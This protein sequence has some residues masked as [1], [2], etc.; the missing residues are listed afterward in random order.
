M[1]ISA[2]SLEFSISIDRQSIS[3]ALSDVERAFSRQVVGIQVQTERSALEQA[4]R[5]IDNAFRDKKVRVG[6]DI[7]A[8]Q[9]LDLGRQGRQGARQF[10]DGFAADIAVGNIVADGVGAAIDLIG[11]GIGAVGNFAGSVAELG[12][13][14]EQ[15]AIAFETILGS[16]EAAESTLSDLQNFAANTPFEFTGVRD[17]GQSLLAFGFQ[18]QELIPALTAVGNVA[19]G[20]GADFNELALIYGKARTQGTLFAEDINQLTERGIPIIAQLAEQFGV[21]ESQIKKLVSEG[22]VTFADLETAFTSLTSE[23]GTFFNLIEKQSATFGGR[24]SNLADTAD[25]FKIALFDAF[26]P[27]LTAAIGT[28]GDIFAEVARQSDGL[29][30]IVDASTRLKNELENSPEIVQEFGSAFADLADVAVDQLAAIVD[31]ITAFVANEDAVKGVADAIRGLGDVIALVGTGVQGIIGLTE[32]LA[33]LGLFEPNIAKLADTVTSFDGALRFLEGAIPGLAQIIELLERMGAITPEALQGLDGAKI[34]EDATAQL[35]GAFADIANAPLQPV[36]I[37][38][39]IP[40][41]KSAEDI[42]K[43]QQEAIKKVG[44][45][46]DAALA[47]VETSQAQRFAEIRQLQADGIIDETEAQSRIADVAAETTDKIIA[48]KQREIGQ[49]QQLRDQGKITEEQAT[50]EIIALQKEVADATLDRIEQEIAAQ[51]RAKQAALEKIDAELQR[52]QQLDEIRGIENDIA[53]DA[54]SSQQELLGAQQTLAASKRELIDTELQ[55]ALQRAEAED[56]INGAAQVREAIL[57]N[58]LAAIAEEQGFK[59]QQLDLQIQQNQL[60]TQRAIQL[61]E[62]AAI[63]ADIAVQK[64]RAE[65]ASSEEIAGLERIRD[66]RQEQVDQSRDAAA[67][68]NAIDA[69]LQE[70]LNVERAISEEKARQN[71][72]SDDALQAEKERV[73]EL[74]KARDELAQQNQQLQDNISAQQNALA[75]AFTAEG[76]TEQ[77]RIDS[78][79]DQ[80]RQATSAG[81]FDTLDTGDFT[82]ALRDVESALRSG[83]DRSVLRAAQSSGDQELFAQL[84]GQVGRGDL[85][86][87]VS[88]DAEI[89]RLAEAQQ[90]IVDELIILNEKIEALANAPRALTIQTPDPVADAGRVVSD[91]QRNRFGGVNP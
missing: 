8:D 38:E 43:E 55:G 62:I 63:E 25:Q 56:D 86:G 73:E 61:A 19:A 71:A 32:V 83:D 33:E 39:P 48:E 5:Q 46:I 9:T 10:N 14:A 88:A 23:G 13:Q 89:D 90:P 70:G 57:Q 64:A 66:L 74:G 45:D 41:Q 11:Q 29:G 79:Q 28:I 35:E 26:S 36:T 17:A 3:R 7:D 49:I 84:L 30:D 4:S 58:Q 75:G 18:A 68:Q 60:E 67:N 2:G 53:S 81:L 77:Q 59:Q 40:P 72:F 69:A 54:L 24:L 16:A 15:S 44:D 1:S 31:S 27:G 6:V 80:F 85:A 91:I 51:E 52:A 87:L 78:I 65:G 47:Q 22:Q 76:D 37:P 82:K 50:T 34:A 42:L 20:V 12:N 21:A